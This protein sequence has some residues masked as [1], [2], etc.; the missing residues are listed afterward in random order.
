MMGRILRIELRRSAALGV[1]LLS[2]VVATA[3]LLSYTEGFAGRWMQLAV[4]G[5]SLLMVMCPLALAGGAW[6]GRRDSRSRVD[7]LFTSTARPRWQRVLPTAGALAITLVTAY[8]LMLLIGA[9]WVL[10]TAG[11][12]PI[13]AIAVSA[14]GVLSLIAAGWL[15]MAAGRAMPRLVTAPALAVVSVALLA[16][17]PDYLSVASMVEDRSDPAALLLTPVYIGGL[18]DLQTVVARVNLTQALWLAALA[19]TGLLLLGA[20]GR[21]AITLAVLPA[22]LG[23]AVAIPLM[24]TGGYDAAAA[25]DPDAAELVC[26]NDGWQVCVTRAHAGLLPDVVG[27]AR[28]ALTMMA[29]KLPGAPS[30]AVETRRVQ[31]WAQPDDAAPA[32]K[33]DRAHTLVFDAPPIGRTGRAD[34]TD[35]DFLPGLLEA[36]W[37]QD[38]GGQ[39]EDQDAYLART[40]AAAWLTGQLPV[41]QSWWVPGDPERVSAAYQTLIG[42]P[43][44][45]QERRMV[46]ARDAALAC[47]TDALRSILPTD[48][49]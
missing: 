36:A 16:L 31:S 24:P 37:R 2:L 45:E 5:R 30:R 19:A 15:G 13:A 9:A 3:T 10:P 25:V 18:D 21:R 33:A 26:D 32:A 34:L 47:R 39:Q 23:A 40:V 11:Y 8:I 48:G 4:S 46:E 6:L 12:F 41:A 43:E 22:V 44:A 42:L 35:A 49:P 20:V 27:P 1:A 7:E 29:A 28:L 14:V 17:L 38:C